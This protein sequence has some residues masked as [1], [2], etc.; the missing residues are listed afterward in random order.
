[1]SG[2]P[3]SWPGTD[4]QPIAC[5]EKL[6]VLAENHAEARQVLQDAFED[7][8]LMGVDEVAMRRILAEMVAAL[9]SPKRP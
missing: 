9:E 2:L 5:R 7:A 4:G 1:V 3:A 6:K 8:V